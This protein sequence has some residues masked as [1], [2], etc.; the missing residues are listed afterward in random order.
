MVDYRCERSPCWSDRCRRD[1]AGVL[2]HLPLP[3]PHRRARPVIPARRA[4][5]VRTGE[6]L[7][8]FRQRHDELKRGLIT[9][10]FCHQRDA[11]GADSLAARIECDRLGAS[12]EAA[13]FRVQL[14][15]GDP[16]W[17]CWQMPPSPRPAPSAALL[18]G[19]NYANARTASKPPSR[20]SF[21]PPPGGFARPLRHRRQADLARTRQRPLHS[22]MQP[23]TRFLSL[24]V[25]AVTQE[26]GAHRRRS[27]L[28]WSLR[29]GMLAQR[30]SGLICAKPIPSQIRPSAMPNRRCAAHLRSSAL[31]GFLPVRPGSRAEDGAAIP[32]LDGQAAG[33]GPCTL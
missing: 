24:A 27:V 31:S 4:T 11:A 28:E 7:Q 3:E 17:R 33:L 18:T 25:F 19:M 2:H 30:R 9:L 16:G 10:W 23:R 13:R 20:R 26:R 5:P 32:G 1:P 8:R 22:S 29:S 21:T 15:S 14:V 12:A 6:C